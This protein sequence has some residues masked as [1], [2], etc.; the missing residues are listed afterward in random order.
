MSRVDLRLWSAL[1]AGALVCGVSAG[2]EAQD[3]EDEYKN[4][5]E[6]ATAI[7]KSGDLRSA[8]IAYLEVRSR[9]SGP[10]LDYS[11]ARTYH[12]LYQ[13]GDA[14]QFYG[15]VMSDYG[16]AED[17]P[18]FTKA[19]GYYTELINCEQWGSVQIDCSDAGATLYINDEMT[20][21]C[22]NRS[23]TMPEGTYR[24]RLEATG[25]EPVEES[26]RVENGA[27]ETLSLALEAKV[28][29]KIVEVPVE[30]PTDGGGSINWGAW[31]LV[32]GGAVMLTA[33]AYFNA[34]GYDSMVDVQRAA[35]AG[36]NAARRSAEDDV[37]LNQVLT[38]VFFGVGLAAVAGGATWL[39]IDS[40][41]DGSDESAAQL[42][43]SAGP[44]D[45]GGAVTLR[46]T[47]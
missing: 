33:A 5:I 3:A 9:F 20:G 10:E 25:T 19:A 23:Y 21:A 42:D 34:A 43:I 7:Y 8:L 39:I 14:L 45:G 44:L 30:V 27:R 17:N 46:A 18:L 15:G 32:G 22:M 12:R 13:C 26:L 47:F 29:E 35:D 40:L 24:F 28:V 2:A 6:A 36:D 41:D 31:S 16:L 38:G 1:I 37:A 11:L 4:R